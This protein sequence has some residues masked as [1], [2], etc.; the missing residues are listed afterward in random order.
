VRLEESGKLYKLEKER[1]LAVGMH[2][3]G[4]TPKLTA[5]LNS[6]SQ[7]TE[8]ER[9]RQK[10]RTTIMCKLKSQNIKER[11]RR[12]LVRPPAR[13]VET[14]ACTHTHAHMRTHTH[15]QMTE[16]KP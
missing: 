11:G 1:E 7:E 8:R 12:P 9:S 2:R 14:R 10:Q 6:A 3:A 16:W 4:M 15:A 13:Q 5:K